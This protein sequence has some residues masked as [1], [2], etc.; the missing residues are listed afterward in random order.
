MSP[1]VPWRDAWE[2]AHYGADG[3]YRAHSNPEKHFRTAIMDAH[4]RLTQILEELHEQYRRIGEP[5]DFTVFD[6]GSGNAALEGALR[7]YFAE[8]SLNWQLRSHNFLDGDVR[9]LKSLGGAGAV[10]AHELLDDIPCTIAELDDNLQPVRIDVDPL[11]GHERLGERR[12][13]EEEARWL[14]TWW[15]ATV[16]AAR[17]EIG[18]TRDNTWRTLLGL[19]DSGCAIMIDYCTTQQ[20]RLTGLFDSGTL[21]GYQ[22]GRATRPLP[23]G[24]MNITAHVALESLIAVGTDLGKPAPEIRRESAH[25]DFHWLVQPL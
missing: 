17:R 5:T 13:T 7:D 22:H 11:T 20:E 12:I 23:D 2:H 18:I 4:P 10:I 14:D 9:N 25:S 24:S 6:A 1:Y 21:I 19:F 16:P 15:P 8:H 3:F